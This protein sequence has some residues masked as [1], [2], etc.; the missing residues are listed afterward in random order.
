M[1]PFPRLRKAAPA[2]RRLLTRDPGDGRGKLT[3]YFAYPFRAFLW[4]FIGLF[5]VAAI[6]SIIHACWQAEPWRPEQAVQFA[7]DGTLRPIYAQSELERFYSKARIAELVQR[8]EAKRAALSRDVLHERRD[9][10]LPV[11][12]ANTRSL[13]WE[14]APPG[15][16]GK[17]PAQA[18]DD[19]FLLANLPRLEQWLH[20]KTP[21][22]TVPANQAVFRAAAE[23][24]REQISREADLRNELAVEL[25]GLDPILPFGWLYV[26]GGGWL[27]EVVFWS[28]LGVL[29]NTIIG[30][31]LA[32]RDD[33][34]QP[35]EFVMV[36][37]KVLLAPLLA[38]ICVAIWTTGL[39]ESKVS[40]LNLPYFLVFS[41]FLGFLTEGLYTRLRDFA[42][43][44]VP[45]S[46]T[47]SQAKLEA[48]AVSQPYQ[49]VNPAPAPAA[50][51]PK[52][53]AELETKLL[54]VAKSGMEHGLIS[55]LAENH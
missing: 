55:R 9:L 25:R 15:V 23:G 28:L 43:L 41:F 4:S 22:L 14:T 16:L 44:I 1:K 31:I 50:G 35:E 8:I 17:S 40:Y 42:N 48:A 32:C 51:A 5:G 24:V 52:N 29:A 30:I 3:A 6:Y 21:T 12:T 47:L 27:V 20:S 11:M 36:I 7:T 38:V 18:T 37:P 54:A 49:Y 53:L 13:V 19:D 26:Q 2:H 10:F 39:T 34:Y 45:P 46:V 33:R